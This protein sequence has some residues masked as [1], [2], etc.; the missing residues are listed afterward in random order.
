MPN[1]TQSGG[2]R[3]DE[4]YSLM[5][6][7]FFSLFAVV[8]VLSFEPAPEYR[9]VCNMILFTVFAGA[10]A[11]FMTLSARERKRT[12]ESM[13]EPAGHED[14][15]GATIPSHHLPGPSKR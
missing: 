4:L 8:A 13:P 6:L 2:V 9:I 7:L 12:A 3:R 1:E 5:A 10:G 14:P 15:T 11:W